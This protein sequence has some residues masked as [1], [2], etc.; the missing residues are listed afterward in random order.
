MTEIDPPSAAT[1]A[2][3]IAAGERS[4]VD[5][6]TDRLDRID[7]RNDRTNAFVT[8]LGEAAQKT[9]RRAER[10]VE[11][12]EQLGPLHGVP[13][14]IKDLS[15]MA[16]VRTTFGSAAFADNVADTNAILVDRLEAAGAIPVGKTNACEFGHRGTTDNRVFGPT[17]TPFD[18]ARNAGGSSGGSAAAV[19]DGLVPVAMGGDGG[20]SIRIPAACCGV[21]G[22]NPSFGRVPHEVRPDAF[23]E[24]TPFVRRGPLT[25][26]VRDAALVMEV[27]GGP[28]PRDPFSL[29]DDGVAYLDAVDRPIDDLSIAYSPDL[30]LFPLVDRVRAVLDEAVTAF[31]AAGAQVVETD[32]DIEHSLRELYDAWKTTWAAMFAGIAEGYRA[33]GRDLLGDHRER[34]CPSFA[35]LV[36]TGMETTVPELRRATRVRTAFRDALNDL[37]D[38]YDLLVTST[39]T[40]PPVENTDDT[41]GPE[42]V[43]GE[44]VGTPIGWCLTYPFNLVENPSASVPAGLDA[45]GLPVGM[46]VIGRRFDDETVLA[47]SAAV[48]R[49]RPWIDDLPP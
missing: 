2:D 35:D 3:R 47:A 7:D 44:F 16:G 32:P 45:G 25:R 17:S 18:T 48:E 22:Y 4:P 14:G 11:T 6:V 37:H 41:I 46:Q 20:G 8:V 36:K 33:G 30:G 24:H 49:E 13:V 31:E 21:F 26:T 28:D 12:D 39:L 38:Q 40:R 23:N 27:I 5:V 9:A 42:T 19:A 1:L 29:P 15:P 43:D 10:A 34:L